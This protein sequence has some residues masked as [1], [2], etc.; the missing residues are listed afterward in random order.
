MGTTENNPLIEEAVLYAHEQQVLIVAASG[1]SEQADASYPAAYP[2]VI[3]VGAV[4]ARGEH[5]EFSNYG[6]YLSL[7]A[8]GYALNAAWPGNG[9]AT[10]Q[11]DLG[12]RADRLRRH[13]RD[14]VERRGVTMSA[15]KRRKS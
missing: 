14:H 7:T 11:R 15:R 3:S 4:D 13:R 8:P 5:L 2:S 1:N 9:Y 12:Q 6:T 10:D